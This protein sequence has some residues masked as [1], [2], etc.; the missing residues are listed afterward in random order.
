MLLEPGRSDEEIVRRVRPDWESC[1]GRRK[2]QGVWLAEG[3]VLLL[4]QEEEK[5]RVLLGAP[6]LVPVGG[7]LQAEGAGAWAGQ[8]GLHAQKY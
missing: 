2:S 3:G 6:F 4:V 5:V 8:R 7:A 1:G